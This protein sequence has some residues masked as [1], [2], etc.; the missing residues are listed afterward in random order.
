MKLVEAELRGRGFQIQFTDTMQEFGSII[1]WLKPLQKLEFSTNPDYFRDTVLR[2]LRCNDESD[3]TPLQLITSDEK[4]EYVG[5]VIRLTHSPEIF[6]DP[7]NQELNERFSVLGY[8]YIS[9]LQIRKDLRGGIFGPP[10]IRD[11]RDLI[12]EVHERAWAVVS[13]LRML[14]YYLSVGAR[15]ESPLEN[16]DHLWIIS[17]HRPSLRPP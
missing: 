9:C 16:T 8:Q 4:A 6:T 11:V 14:R 13:S 2:G 7:R 5:G 17:W 15:S 12:L 3:I 10:L 1:P